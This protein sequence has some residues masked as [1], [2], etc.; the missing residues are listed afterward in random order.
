MNPFSDGSRIDRHTQCLGY[1]L[2]ILTD[3]LVGIPKDAARLREVMRSRTT[4]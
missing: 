2:V 3:V 4:T 1:L